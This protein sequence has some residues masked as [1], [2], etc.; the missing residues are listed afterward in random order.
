M[1]SRKGSSPLAHPSLMAPSARMPL[2]RALQSVSWVNRLLLACP[3]PAYM[4]GQCSGQ[5]ASQQ[6]SPKIADK[7]MVNV[8]ADVE[9][10]AGQG[11]WHCQRRG[12]RAAGSVTAL[13][14]TSPKLLQSWTPPDAMPLH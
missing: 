4:E 1:P 5:L 12:V 13:G 2:S 9:C 8:S 10:S 7:Q 14:Q 3:G 11:S 6:V